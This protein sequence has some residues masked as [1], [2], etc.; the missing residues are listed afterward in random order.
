M[1]AFGVYNSNHTHKVTA[2]SGLN[3]EVARSMMMI[4]DDSMSL[5]IIS[6]LLGLVVAGGV[7]LQ[8]ATSGYITN[9]GSPTTRETVYAETAL[10]FW[11]NFLTGGLVVGLPVWLRIGGMSAFVRTFAG[12]GGVQVALVGMGVAGLGVAAFERWVERGEDVVLA[13]KKE[14]EGK[15]QGEGSFMDA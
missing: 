1:V 6:F 2:V 10:Q 12:V 8:L 4:G 11:R 15:W 7:M 5:Q 13:R 14:G 9:S 3:H